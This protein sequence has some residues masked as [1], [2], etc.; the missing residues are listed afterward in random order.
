M[1]VKQNASSTSLPKATT[2]KCVTARLE[3]RYGRAAVELAS[4]KI[5][6]SS[7]LGGTLSDVNCLGL[8]IVSYP[9]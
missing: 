8:G 1:M 4:G 7:T 2:K 6:K 5:N 3:T 9:S